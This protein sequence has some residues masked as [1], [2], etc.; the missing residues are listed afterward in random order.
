MKICIPTLGMAPNSGSGG[1]VY[2]REFCRAL[3]GQADVHYHHPPRFC[4][5]PR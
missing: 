2:E 1:E 3:E 5:R 4:G